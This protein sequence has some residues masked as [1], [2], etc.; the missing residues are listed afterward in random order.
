MVQDNY[1]YFFG[2]NPNQSEASLDFAKKAGGKHAK[3]AL[4]I[5]YRQG[6]EEYLP[7]YTDPW[8]RA[9]V[10]P[11]NIDVIIPNQ[12]GELNVDQTIH[13]LQEATGIYIGG[14][15]T[16]TYHAT[17]VKEPYK[18]IMQ[19]KY[20]AGTPIAGNS[21]GALLLT[22]QVVLSSIDTDSGETIHL[23]GLG[24]VQD[25]LISVHYS[26]WNDAEHLKG[27]LANTRI[28]TGYGIDDHACLVV[29]NGRF[30]K[31]LGEE[32]VFVVVKN[33]KSS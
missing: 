15:H 10:Q 30:H 5:I 14:G 3:I 21:A 16:E 22:D 32:K 23:H 1:L 25:I 2:G 29:K 18:S 8:I 20:Y 33:E 12:H 4:L 9:G 7:R 11:Q 31:A 26:K 13:T 28:S 17:Y 19:E 6:W 27:S 24:F